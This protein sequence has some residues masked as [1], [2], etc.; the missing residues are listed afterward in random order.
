MNKYFID[1]SRIILAPPKKETKN[2]SKSDFVNDNKVFHWFEGWKTVSKSNF[3][4][5][6][7]KLVL[8]KLFLRIFN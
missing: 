4:I 2:I 6:R 3:W 7:N 8:K 5:V 1:V